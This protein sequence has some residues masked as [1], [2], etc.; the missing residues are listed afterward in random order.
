[1]GTER[2]EVSPLSTPVFRRPHSFI[3]KTKKTITKKTART[4]SEIM[5][6]IS[7]VDLHEADGDY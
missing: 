2:A 3:T 4:V 1:M 5:P 6:P 7:L